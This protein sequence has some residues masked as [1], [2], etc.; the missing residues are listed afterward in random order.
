MNTPQ[1]G[2]IGFYE[3]TTTDNRG[4]WLR[5]IQSW[6]FSKLEA[7]HDY[8]QWLFPLRKRSP[9]NPA[10]PSLDQEAISEF[11]A[12]PELRAELIRTLEVMLRFYGFSLA[13]SL[14]EP[15]VIC[16]DDFE[17]RAANWMTSGNHNHLRITRI[18][19]CLRALG[20]ENY[21]EAF[22]RALQEVY[23][24][25]LQDRT[26]A[27]SDQSFAFWRSATGRGGWKP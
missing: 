25:E 17:P 23:W 2:L 26:R 18:L 14:E 12:R 10:A 4:R 6:D 7:V 20:C 8:V 21:G 13:G 15:K 19:G 24:S 1:G 3:G 16:S 27:I 22:F 11:R 9:V 5:E